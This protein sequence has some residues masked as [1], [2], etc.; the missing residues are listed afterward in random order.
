MEVGVYVRSFGIFAGERRHRF[1][2][3][4][5]PPHESPGRRTVSTCGDVRRGPAT[6]V[7]R[8][9]FTRP[10]QDPGDTQGTR[11]RLRKRSGHQAA[12]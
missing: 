3:E 9:P 5:H 12:F 7:W 8:A 2:F 6:P 11:R 1:R 4:S 10:D